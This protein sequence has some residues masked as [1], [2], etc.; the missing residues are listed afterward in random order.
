MNQ[1]LR[2]FMRRVKEWNLLYPRYSSN[3]KLTCRR[4]INICRFIILICWALQADLLGDLFS[5]CLQ[6][7]RKSFLRTFQV[8]FSMSCLSFSL[9]SLTKGVLVHIPMRC[10]CKDSGNAAFPAPAHL[11]GAVH[12]LPDTLPPYDGC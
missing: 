10:C 1:Y 12:I 11:G 6:C 4:K 8:G 2:K 5:Q 3:K 7:P 9:L